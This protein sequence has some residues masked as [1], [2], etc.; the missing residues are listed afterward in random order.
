MGEKEHWFWF[1]SQW[2]RHTSRIIVEGCNMWNKHTEAIH[3]NY[4][5]QFSN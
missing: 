1:K 3:W 2:E 5:T 4:S